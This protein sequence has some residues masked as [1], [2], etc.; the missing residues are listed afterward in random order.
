MG[1]AVGN[2]KGRGVGMLVGVDDGS[3]VG[4]DVGMISQIKFRQTPIVRPGRCT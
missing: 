4:I 3:C 1:V 2:E